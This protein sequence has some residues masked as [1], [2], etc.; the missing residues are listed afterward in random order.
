ML[1]GLEKLKRLKSGESRAID[2]DREEE[3]VFEYVD[4]DEYSEVVKKRTEN[5]WIVDDGNADYYEDG[6]EIFEDNEDNDYLNDNKY[7]REYANYGAASKGKKIPLKSKN[8]DTSKSS[9]A[10]GTTS[11]KS[12]SIRSFLVSNQKNVAKKSFDQM[13]V[14]DD[15]LLKGILDDLN[16]STSNR[17]QQQQTTP[18]STRNKRKLTDFNDDDLM[19]TQTANNPFSVA[20]ETNFKPNANKKARIEDNFDDLDDDSL[21]DNN[22]DLPDSLFEEKGTQS[23]SQAT[24]NSTQENEL[25][26]EIKTKSTAQAYSIENYQ[27]ENDENIYEENDGKY[28][29]FYW[30]DIYE[31]FTQPVTVY[32]FG[33]V[34][35]QKIEKFL[36]CCLICKNVEH[37]IF[38]YPRTHFKSD[39]SATVTMDDVENEIRS[40]LLN[41]RIKNFR[42]KTSVKNYAFEKD[43]VT[44]T[45][46]LE[47]LFAP[48]SKHYF[49]TDLNGETFG[50]VFNYN[51]SSLERFIIDLK[52]KGPCWLK[53]KNPEI[54]TSPISWCKFE[55]AIEK[56]FIQVQLHRDENLLSKEVPLSFMTLS[57]K[58]YLNPKTNLNEIIAISCLINREY[59]ISKNNDK[60]IEKVDDH[61]CLITKPSASSQIQLPFNF[62]NET[63]E[64]QYKKTKV[65]VVGTERELISL[66]LT[67]LFQNDPDLLIGHDILQFDLSVL[68]DRLA[69]FKMPIWS[70]LGRLRRSKNVPLQRKE[71]SSV[72]VG[73]LLCDIEIAAKELIRVKSYDLNELSR[74]VLKKKEDKKEFNQAEIK[75]FY[76]KTFD[77]L[78]RLIDLSMIDTSLINDLFIEL[79]V[80]PLYAQITKIAG[81]IFSRTLL[82]GRSE[83]NEYLLLHAFNEKNYILPE[84]KF[85]N[86]K[87]STNNNGELVPT[88]SKRKKA[89]YTGGLVLDPKIGFYDKFILLMDFNS[90]YPSIIQ[91]YKICFTTIDRKSFLESLKDTEGEKLPELNTSL[92]VEVKGILPTEIS[93]LVKQRYEAKKEM[94]KPGI[95]SDLKQ[96]YD[97]QQKA[98]KLT[99]NSMYG[100]L[101]FSNSRFYARPLAAL[102][103]SKGREI[104]RNTKELIESLQSLKLEII[105]GDTD[106]LMINTNKD[107]FEEAENI[108]YKL[109]S[110]VNKHYEQLEI[111]I[112]G[113]F[114]SILLLKKKKYAAVVAKRV[115]NQITF[116]KEV[117][118]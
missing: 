91:E 17:T 82:G 36:S 74:Q 80:I 105:Y 104:L 9:S 84:K 50:H 88:A 72:T 48:S 1:A 60:T 102:I 58:T 95:S 19:P 66:F 68:L 59:F 85:Q 45:E 16:T 114:R 101:G 107:S 111:D 118:G 14:E 39:P 78:L 25:N 112:D 56:P 103:T 33:K 46:Y 38:V 40:V 2:C 27:F 63:V 97:I 81:N 92:G 94:I 67:K 43:I 11:K 7:E 13:R 18:S 70:K 31:D 89:A 53:I 96:Q 29:N 79:N 69:H 61:F 71:R 110:E 32:L 3:A 65:H 30:I 42:S 24:S 47:I 41:Y 35:V 113:V 115:N 106:S 87:F 93:N 62:K 57:L 15:D 44:R 99:A 4:D 10:A 20:T 73:R 49:P 108:G 83:R 8:G 37:K 34:Y 75:S 76:Y 86:S 116:T 64:R 77:N 23:S 54:V 21:L 100:C 26:F 22:F 52:L 5:D 109:K 51:Q 90:L 6:R 98:L 12:T 28:L 55:Y 117:K